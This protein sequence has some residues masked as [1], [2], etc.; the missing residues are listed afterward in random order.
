MQKLQQSLLKHELE[1][2][3]TKLITNKTA[4][5]Q[6]PQLPSSSIPS[7][8]HVESPPLYQNHSGI[9]IDD[10][11]L[12]NEHSKPTR[13]D[14]KRSTLPANS[15]MLN[16]P[17]NKQTNGKKVLNIFHNLLSRNQSSKHQVPSQPVQNSDSNLKN[18]KRTTS[19]TI[20]S[21]FNNIN[22]VN[23]TKSKTDTN[24]LNTPT[25]MKSLLSFN[26]TS[27][28]FFGG[29]SKS[30]AKSGSYNVSGD[31]KG[32][33]NPSTDLKAKVPN[34]NSNKYSRR[35]Y[36]DLAIAHTQFQPKANSKLNEVLSEE[37]A[38]KRPGEENVDDDYDEN[39]IVYSTKNNGLIFLPSPPK[40][41]NKK[42]EHLDYEN[43]GN[44]VVRPVL[45]EEE[46]VI[47]DEEVF[48][49]ASMVSHNNSSNNNSTDEGAFDNC[50][51]SYVDNLRNH[52]VTKQLSKAS[53]LSSSAAAAMAAATVLVNT[54][55]V[56]NE[57][58]IKTG[59]LVQNSDSFSSTSSSASSSKNSGKS[60]PPNLPI[61]VLPNMSLS[62]S[63]SLN[64]LSTMAIRNPPQVQMNDQ[65]SSVM[66]L[67]DRFE[68][69]RPDSPNVTRQQ[70][71]CLSTI[72]GARRP[73]IKQQSKLQQT[74]DLTI[75]TGNL[76]E[77]NSENV[78]LPHSPALS[79]IS[80]TS[81]TRSSSHNGMDNNAGGSSTYSSISF[82]HS[83]RSNHNSNTSSHQQLL[84]T[85][86][87]SEL[88][89]VPL[90]TTEAVSETLIAEDQ[91]NESLEQSINDSEFNF[92]TFM[93]KMASL[94][95]NK[96]SLNKKKFY[97]SYKQVVTCF[98]SILNSSSKQ[99]IS[100]CS[101]YVDF[102]L[103]PVLLDIDSIL[104][105]H[106]LSAI[107]KSTEI[108]SNQICYLLTLDFFKPLLPT[109]KFAC[110][111]ADLGRFSSIQLFED[112][113]SCL[114]S[115]VL[116]SDTNIDNLVLYLDNLRE[117]IK[118]QSTLNSVTNSQ[119]FNLS[120][121]YEF[122]HGQMR[123]QH[124]ISLES[125]ERFD[126]F[127][128]KLKCLLHFKLELLGHELDRVETLADENSQIGAKVLKQLE[129]NLNV[130]LLELDKFKLLVNESGVITNLLLKLCNKMATIE[131]VV[132]LMQHVRL[133]SPSAKSEEIELLRQEFSQTQR[134]KDEAMFL[135]NGIDKRAL[136]VS[137]F[138]QK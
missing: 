43:L 121:L 46:D 67:R 99:S 122:L 65:A 109:T 81:S 51:Y 126:Q 103:D 88:Q 116:N 118:L 7:K 73:P 134:K 30:T 96:P 133:K 123:N 63:A 44:D 36:D 137:D 75:S 18:L 21:N 64:S 97:L 76:R 60:T 107:H 37:C 26:T 22:N 19:S 17:A 31:A 79:S 125:N 135:K 120:L 91:L 9:D 56:V 11:V 90:F 101:F 24:E 45:N 29:N 112:N 61:V 115:M 41:L 4:S 70:Q 80:S 117:S 1:Q 28:L 42:L 127:K 25:G 8:Q 27:M 77:S 87:A 89:N 114:Q 53:L 128:L 104:P 105:Q 10:M 38:E 50:E 84:T 6:S 47:G 100:D 131:N 78:L 5:N 108:Q 119:D 14:L 20:A 95:S 98:E 34:P 12:T 32:S 71:Q 136:F 111:L 86:V 54:Q 3:A 129:D 13:D 35:S 69:L 124:E 49:S 55:S 85:I 62:E 130:T 58:E 113:F 83:A 132:Q 74:P 16:Q 68:Q 48:V 39:N 138:L 94:E 57:E 66:S 2:Q 92:Y 15:Q 59:A 110:V 52:S 40:P 106:R 33:R 72:M 102:I 93:Y 82:E 23:A